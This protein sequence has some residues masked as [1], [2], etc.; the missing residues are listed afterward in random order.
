MGTRFYSNSNFSAFLE[1]LDDQLDVLSFLWELEV[2]LFNVKHEIETNL[3]LLKKHQKIPYLRRLEREL[4]E[5]QRSVNPDITVWLKKYNTTEDEVLGSDNP[6]G[7][8]LH[9]IVLLDPAPPSRTLP[10][11]GRIQIDFLN[12]YHRKFVT[13][14][15]DFVVAYSEGKISGGSNPPR[16]LVK[17]D[18][19]R[20]EKAVIPFLIQEE[21]HIRFRL[22]I[23][24]KTAD[25]IITVKVSVKEFVKFI[26]G[27]R[28]DRL[29]SDPKTKIRDWICYWFRYSHKG[30]P[31]KLNRGTVYDY[32][33]R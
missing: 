14:A 13:E 4:K 9:E 30:K 19:R 12:Y 10:L 21:D 17:R 25:R 18:K 15:L 3:T 6:S 27:L 16:L 24:G 29:I 5:K 20:I 1:A 7:N 28:E 26:S 23:E 32:L 31:M 2:G 22:L 11:E 33:R 8:R